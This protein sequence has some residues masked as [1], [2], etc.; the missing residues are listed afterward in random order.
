[1]VLNILI[2]PQNSFQVWVFQPQIFHFW[3]KVFLREDFPTA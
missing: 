2:V 3:L 1:M